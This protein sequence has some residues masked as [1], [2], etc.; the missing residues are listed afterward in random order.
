MNA[1]HILGVVISIFF[2]LF[3]LIIPKAT[4]RF[5]GYKI[6]DTKGEIEIMATYGGFFLGLSLLA[7]FVNSNGGYDVLGGAWLGAGV[8]RIIAIGKYRK[9]YPISTALAGIEL[10]IGAL[11]ILA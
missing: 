2:S 5:V 9:F 11:L 3:G 6:E 10:L 8:V 4:G 7:L 1:I